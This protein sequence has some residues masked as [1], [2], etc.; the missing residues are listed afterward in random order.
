MNHFCVSGRH[1]ALSLAELSHV[2]P[3]ATL[4]AEDA[5]V[6]VDAAEWDGP[7]LMAQLGGTVKLGDI[8]GVVR[9]ADARALAD[10]IER[11]PRAKRIL[12]GLTVFGSKQLRADR[13]AKELKKELKMRGH[14][15]RWVTQAGDAPLSPAAVAKLKLTTDGY[16]LVVIEHD[17]SAYLGLTTHVQDAD[18]WSHRDYGRPARSARRGML[19]PKLARMM[20]NLADVPDGGTVLDPFCGSGTVLME[21]AVVTGA[22]TIIGSDIDAD[23]VNAS[24]T[25]VEWLRTEKIIS[26][27]RD[28][29]VIQKDV[30]R[31]TEKETGPV[32]AIVTEGHLGPP[33]NGKEGAA[34]LK[35]TAGEITDLWKKSFPVLHALLKK[36]GRVICVWPSFATPRGTASVDLS[37][38]PSFTKFFSMLPPSPFVYRR[39]DQSVTRNI[40]I[41]RKK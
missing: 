13:I 14:A 5:A 2:L 30:R 29:T 7:G 35:T 19:P 37:T 15:V 39:P 27:S 3:H 8:A 41:L 1:P 12:F 21:A 24:R 26:P 34:A 40:V 20:V 31:L 4:V 10:L 25:N 36:D 23:Q 9:S 22:K 18:A 6:L 28:I 17:G 11:H 38:D 16:D 33:L 32:D